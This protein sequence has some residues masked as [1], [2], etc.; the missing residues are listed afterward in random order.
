MGCLLGI[1]LVP[2]SIIKWLF[3]RFGAMIGFA[4]LAVFITVTVIVVRVAVSPQAK[5]AIVQQVNI[6][7]PTI[8]QAPYIIRTS[9]RY[10]YVA[11][12]TEEN[13]TTTLTGFWA[14]ENGEWVKYKTLTL[15]PAY[16]AVVIEKR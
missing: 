11:T 4:I 3:G 7:V 15:T 16:G 5:P 8:K 9:S 1:I 6:K 2:F 13:G 12:Y 14:L 10:Y